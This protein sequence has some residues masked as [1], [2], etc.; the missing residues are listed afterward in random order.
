MKRASNKPRH[1]TRGSVLDDL[2]FS[3]ENAAALKFKAELY[4]A[5]LKCARQYSQKELQIILEEPQPRVSE[6]LNGKIANKSVDKLLHYAGRLGI[7]TKARFAQTHKDVIDKELGLAGRNGLTCCARMPELPRPASVPRRKSTSSTSSL[8]ASIALSP[9]P[10]AAW[11][12][13]RPTKTSIVASF[14]T[15]RSR[16]PKEPSKLLCELAAAQAMFL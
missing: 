13:L 15:A 12:G 8:P 11:T 5:I 14:P 6:L 10:M 4:Q 9:T 7:E 3:P 16:L 1:V 2:A